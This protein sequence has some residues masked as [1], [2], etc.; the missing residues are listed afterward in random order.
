MHGCL[1]IISQADKFLQ[2]NQ[3]Q[4]AIRLQGE[5]GIEKEIYRSRTSASLHQN[6][7]FPA[8]FTTKPD[9]LSPPHQSHKISNIYE[10]LCTIENVGIIVKF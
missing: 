8:L 4:A 1:Q 5:G 2:A 6:F 10:I 9:D 7:P 3:G